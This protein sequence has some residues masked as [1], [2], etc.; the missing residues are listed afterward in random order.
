MEAAAAARGGSMP[1]M[2]QAAQSRKQW[3]AVSEHRDEDLER[4]KLG[5]S[6]ERTIYEG[7]EPVDVDFCSI[8]I[9]GTLDHDLL[10]QRLHDIARQ[11]EELQ[12][13][14]TELRA[15][16]IA[17]SEIMEI[18]NNF[19][20]QLKEHANAASKLQEQFHEKEQAILDLERKL[21]EKDRELHATKLDNEAAWAKEGLLREQNKELANFRRERDHTE[22]ERAQHIQQL[23]DLQDH[24]QEKERQL[25]EL[26]EQHR[27][28]EEAILYKDEQLNEA[29]AWIARVQEMDGLQSSTLQNQLREHTE[30]YNQFWLGCQRQFAEMERHHMHTVQQLQLELAD[31]RQRSGTYTD[32]SRV[33]NSTS[34]EASQFGRNNGNQIGMNTSNGNTGALPNGNPEDVSSFSSTVNASSQVDHASS[35]P[36]GPSSLLG[37]PPFLSPGQVTGMHPFVLHQP[38]VPHSMPPQVPQSHV[39][40]FQSIPAM[41]SL[42]QWQNQQAPPESLQIAT[43]T[44]PPSS[45]NEQNLMRS[46][47]KYNYE[48]SVNGQPFHQDYLDVQI[49]Q[50][51]EPEP[52]I[53][54]SPVEVQVLESINSSYLISPETD[55]S[56][57][58]ISSQFTDSLT[59]DSLEKT[60][61]TDVLT[62]EKPNS[63]INSSRPD[64]AVHV[65]LNENARNNTPNTGLP[66]SFASTGHISAP[67]V[68]RTS[69]AALLDERSLL[70]CMVRT[71][72]AGGRIRISSTLPNRLGRMLAPLHWHD[73]KKKYGKL[74]D[75]V[76]AHTE[77]FVIEGDYIQLREGAQEMIAA[78][79]AAA[80]VAAARAASSPFILPSVAVTPVA[81]TYFLK[82]ML[83]ID[84]KNEVAATPNASNT[85]LQSVKQNQQLNGVSFGVSGGL[86]NVKILSKFK[87]LNGSE[88][89]PGQ[90]SVPLNGGNGALDRS[91]ANGRLSSSFVGKQHGRMT[92]S[93]FTSN[94][95]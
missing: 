55:Q 76:A 81:Q 21:E 5:H 18:Q 34:K 72:P 88:S 92:N 26:Q 49:R 4:S 31:A 25:I 94:R 38:G 63:P 66:E 69:E 47:A 70:A 7:R 51:A 75:F 46:D 83:S 79:A 35:V 23:H 29:Q 19:D 2:T 91:M 89:T 45:H 82:K 48:T 54:S 3:R 28:A 73:Y 86:S 15:Q 27:L 40:N 14:E 90:S 32:E 41:S 85:H 22:A 71:I 61:E 43:Q 50:G 9:D 87:E 65:S 58:Q 12:H 93:A 62:A 20:V 16:M 77:L 64:T 67:S 74:N 57:P 39:G 30:H 13:M 8:S 80:R 84:S 95:R 36:I 37:M 24:I 68:G 60:S 11:R 59:L 10:Q 1:A 42:Q 33:A 44:E 52:V 53:S 6:H 78:T 56:L 17:R